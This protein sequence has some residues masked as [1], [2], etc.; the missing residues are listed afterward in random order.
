VPI[1]EAVPQQRS[2]E[3]IDTGWLQFL[4]EQFEFPYE[5]VYPS[6]IDAGNLNAKYDV[7]IIPD[8]AGDTSTA[9]RTRQPEASTI[10]A[11]YRARLGKLTAAT[12]GPQIKTFVQNGGTLITVGRG[13]SFAYELGIP[14]RN[15]LVDSAGKSLPRSKFYVPGS[16]LSAALDTTNAIAWGMKPRVDLFFDSSPAFNVGLGRDAR[17]MDGVA[18]YDSA[19]PLRS[20]WAWGQSALEGKS[21]IAVARLGKGTV[22]LYGPEVYFRNQSHGSFPLLN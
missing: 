20:G 11:E 10:P 2:W 7:L 18:S 5:L 16:V 22:V 14:V 1:G 17:G 13:A 3:A 9:F 21:A 19:T 6:T 4:F 12:S 15:A 8:E